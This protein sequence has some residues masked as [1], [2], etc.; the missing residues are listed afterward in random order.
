MEF[1]TS[2]ITQKIYGTCYVCSVWNG[3]LDSESTAQYSDMAPSLNQR[4]NR[5]RYNRFSYGTNRIIFNGI[6]RKAS[7]QKGSEKPS[8][9]D[10]KY[11]RPA[12]REECLYDF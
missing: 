3:G 9:T 6:M 1:D 10:L 7:S 11:S 8:P 4:V 12:L 5:N 2:D